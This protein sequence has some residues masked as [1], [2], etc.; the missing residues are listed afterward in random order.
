MRYLYAYLRTSKFTTVT[1]HLQQSKTDPFK[2]GHSMTL[3]AM[4]FNIY[5]PS[6]RAINQFT[7]VIILQSGPL[8]YGGNFTPLS[9]D[10]LTS[11]LRHLLQQAG[12][13]Q[14]S[15]IQ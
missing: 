1:I 7:E 13:Q 14:D 11:V 4:Y 6:K 2:Q 12:Y 8:Y 15:C 5:L 3:Q 10:Q 9:R